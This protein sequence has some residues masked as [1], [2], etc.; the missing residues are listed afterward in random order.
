MSEK[1]DIG[2]KTTV[3]AGWLS[4]RE[5]DTNGQWKTEDGGAVR[6]AP[7]GGQNNQSSGNSGSKNSSGKMCFFYLSWAGEGRRGGGGRCTADSLG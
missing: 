4:T 6:S 3:S 1:K 5:C 2:K 7:T